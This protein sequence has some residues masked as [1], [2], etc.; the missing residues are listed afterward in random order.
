MKTIVFEDR[1]D[2][3]RHLGDTLKGFPLRN[4]LVLAIPCGGVEV[5]IPLAR[6]IGAELDVVLSRKL[7]APNQ[8]ELAIGAV[9]EAG[10]VYL[11][12][13]AGNMRGVTE[14][15]LEEECARQMKT[16]EAARGLFRAVRPQASAV[17]RSV[18]IVDDGIATGATMVAALRTV[19]RERPHEIIAAVPVASPDR[20][21]E[22]GRECDRVVCLVQ[23]ADFWAVGQFYRHFGPVSGEA[24]TEMLRR[25]QSEQE[26]PRVRP[27]TQEGESTAV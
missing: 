4:P 16:I 17:G 1:A 5:G 24:V 14:K 19:R 13:H 15:Y 25:F 18:I 11:T 10:E 9:S 21:A 3:G 7:R 12:P 22:I 8:P 23:P 6:A 20:L 27:G 2:A 26:Q